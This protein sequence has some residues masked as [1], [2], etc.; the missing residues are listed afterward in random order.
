MTRTSDIIPPADGSYPSDRLKAIVAALRSRLKIASQDNVE[1]RFDNFDR[2]LFFDD[3][4]LNPD[5]RPNERLIVSRE[6][7]R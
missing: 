3:R 7:L 2:I 4:D 6:R 5:V 1:R